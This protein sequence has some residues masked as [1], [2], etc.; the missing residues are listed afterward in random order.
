LHPDSAVVELRR[1][2]EQLPDVLRGLPRM[3]GDT[4][5]IGWAQRHLEQAP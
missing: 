4:A 2:G 3:K 1:F 5:V